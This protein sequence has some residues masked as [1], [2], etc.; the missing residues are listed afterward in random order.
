MKTADVA[1]AV[2]I[3]EERSELMWEGWKRFNG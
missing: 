2:G 1:K 3:V